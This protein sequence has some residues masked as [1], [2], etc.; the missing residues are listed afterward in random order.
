[1]DDYQLDTFVD[2][3]RPCLGLV[4]CVTRWCV[5]HHRLILM[6]SGSR[7]GPRE[8]FTLADDQSSLQEPLAQEAANLTQ[9]SVLQRPDVHFCSTVE[10]LSEEIANHEKSS[11]ERFTGMFRDNVFNLSVKRSPRSH[12]GA[13]LRAEA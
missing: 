3:Y 5:A 2:V 8:D 11:K 12:A 9:P 1:M 10:T 7:S 13:G 6:T 4:G